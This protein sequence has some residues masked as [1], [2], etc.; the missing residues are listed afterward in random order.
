MLWGRRLILY[1]EIAFSESSGIERIMKSLGMAMEAAQK[2]LSEYGVLAGVDQEPNGTSGSIRQTVLEIL[3]P[4]FNSV[5]EQ[6][7]NA[8][9]YTASR[10]RG[11]TVDFVYLL[12]PVARWPGVDKVLQAMLSM[13]V[14]TL[15]PATILPG[16][17]SDE[18]TD[19]SPTSCLAVAAGLALRGASP[20]E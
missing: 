7:G 5:A 15:D 2:L 16:A 14:R 19:G 17:G 18:W 8:L 13:P 11:D 20:D 12:G 1:R 4:E 6:V 9:V 3:R 10:T